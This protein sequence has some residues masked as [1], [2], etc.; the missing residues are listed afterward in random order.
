MGRGLMASRKP[1]NMNYLDALIEARNHFH[2]F[3]DSWGAKEM[4]LQYLQPE[5][6]DTLKKADNVLKEL[7]Y[8]ADNQ[9]DLI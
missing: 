2:K 5:Q 9:N 6:L 1:V 7:L 8:G 3:V 4:H